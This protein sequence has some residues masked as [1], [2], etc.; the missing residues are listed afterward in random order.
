MLAGT[1][2]SGVRSMKKNILAWAGSIAVCLGLSGFPVSAQS[3]LAD[4]SSFDIDGVKLGMS[5]ADTLRAL[6]ARFGKNAPIYVDHEM[7]KIRPSVLR[8]SEIRFSSQKYTIDI[9]F[10]DNTPPT[11]AAPEQV[12]AISL[13]LNRDIP[14]LGLQIRQYASNFYRDVVQK[15]GEPTNTSASTEVS[16]C[17]ATTASP[18]VTAYPCDPFSPYMKWNYTEFHPWAE[19]RL[20]DDQADNRVTQYYKDHLSSVVGR[21]PL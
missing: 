16:W 7:T 2:S 14:D 4:V 11:S 6:H 8:I 1:P 12:K 10:T 20:E 15:Y 19:L 13:R 9:S 3:R 5:G 17:E 21:A 18:A